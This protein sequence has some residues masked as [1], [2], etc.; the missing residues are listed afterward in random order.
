MTEDNP[1]VS[2]VIPTFNSEK[3]LAKCLESIRNQT[4]KNIEIIVADSYSGDDTIEIAQKFGTKIVTTPG[5]LLGARY[6]GLKESRGDYVLLLDSDQILDNTAIARASE[7]IKEY[8]MVCLE[9]HSYKP[10]TW[11]QWLF[12]A[13][14]NLVHNLANVHL[15]PFEGALLARFYKRRVLETAFEAIPKDVMPIVVA[16]DHAIIYYEA[17]R[18]SQRIRVLPN[19]VWHIEP[20]SLWSLIKKNY[21]YGKST[22]SLVKSGYYQELLKKKIRFR[23]RAL[24]DWKLGLQTYLLLMLKGVGYCI[25]YFSSGLECLLEGEKN[26]TR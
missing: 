22:Y 25:G 4:Y 24:K 12:E 7:M 26:E 10:K 23:K 1:L 2:I 20:G 5:K 6:R 11:I 19:A 3:T 21:R 15:D 14:R 13:D 8:D 9:E 17:H 16:H 18:V